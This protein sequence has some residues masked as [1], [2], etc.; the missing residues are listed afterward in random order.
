[1]FNNCYISKYQIIFVHSY[2]KNI[3]LAD[4]DLGYY[5][6]F[7]KYKKQNKTYL[8]HFIISGLSVDFRISNFASHIKYNIPNES[9][10]H[11]KCLE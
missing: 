11:I 5:P 6:L 7:I 2:F 9:I 4:S 3:K 1:M 10:F 8:W